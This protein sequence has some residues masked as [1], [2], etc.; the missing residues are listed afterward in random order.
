ME[1]LQLFPDLTITIPDRITVV[2]FIQNQN[3]YTAFIN[4]YKRNLFFVLSNFLS[5]KN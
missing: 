2:I 3:L 4:I 5:H 1:D